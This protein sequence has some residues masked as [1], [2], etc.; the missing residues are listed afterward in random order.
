VWEAGQSAVAVRR[1]PPGRERGLWDQRPEGRR[2]AGVPNWR[3]DSGR[4]PDVT[5]MEA[6]D[7]GK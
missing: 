7:F 1:A 5:M 4:S 2:V 6:T 3:A